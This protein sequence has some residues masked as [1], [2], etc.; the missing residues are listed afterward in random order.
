MKTLYEAIKSCSVAYLT[1]NSLPLEVQLPPYLDQLLHFKDNEDQDWVS[2]DD[3]YGYVAMWGKDM[4]VGWRLPSLVPWKS[5][6]LLDSAIGGSLRRSQIAP[7]DQHLAEGL[8][9]FLETVN[10]TLSY[11]LRVFPSRNCF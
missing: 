8:F 4:S 6:L 3:E 11:V 9:R 2:D 5:L 7:E 1:I 10:V